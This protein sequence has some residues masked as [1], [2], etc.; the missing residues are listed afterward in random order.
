MLLQQRQKDVTDHRRYKL[1]TFVDMN[2]NCF[3]FIAN[4]ISLLTF[5]RLDGSYTAIV[6]QRPHL[7][8]KLTCALTLPL[9]LSWFVTFAE[10]FPKLP[11]ITCIEY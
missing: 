2:N 8:E 6:P 9:E 11:S 1:S 4:H 5:R 10:E 3:P 7:Q